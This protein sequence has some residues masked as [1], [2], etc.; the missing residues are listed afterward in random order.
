MPLYSRSA[1]FACLAVIL[2]AFSAGVAAAQAP[3]PTMRAPDGAPA[4][5]KD[6]KIDWKGSWD[7]TLAANL[8]PGKN[9]QKTVEADESLRQGAGVIVRLREIAVL[10]AMVE[11]FPAPTPKRQQ[12]YATIAKA[13]A[14]LGDRARAVGWLKRQ[15]NDYPDAKAAAAEA[16]AGIL[17]YSCPFDSAPEAA[18]WA[19]Y[20]GGGLEA[21]VKAGAVPGNAPAVIQARERLCVA[22]RQGQRPVLARRYLDSLRAAE[23][24][25]KWWQLAKAQLLLGAGH[26]P[27]A[28]GLM[29][30]AGNA[31]QAGAMREQARAGR[32][33]VDVAPLP[34][35]LEQR[36]ER[37]AGAIRL[38][39]TKA[40]QNAESVQD[41]LTR[42]ADSGAI[43][44]VDEELQASSVV[45]LDR[46][47]QALKGELGPLRQWEQQS[48]KRLADALPASGGEDELAKLVRRYPWA[49]RV[50]EV[51]VERGEQALREG[52]YD[53]AAGAFET[54]AAHAEDPAVLAQ[55]R[56]GLWLALGQG[57]AGREAMEQAMAQ[58]PDATA[59]PRGGEAGT[60]GEAKAFVRKVTS[61]AQEAVAPLPRAP[62]QKLQLPAAMAAQAPASRGRYESWSLGPWAIRRIEW[63]GRQLVLSG[64]RYIA[65]YDGSTMALRWHHAAPG[66][67]EAPEETPGES[68]VARI[69]G[70]WRPAALASPYSSSSAGG[71]VVYALF[72][73]GEGGSDLSAFEAASGR[74][75]W[76]TQGR[77]E[78]E[79]MRILSEPTAG[80]D[81]VYVLAMEQ[82]LRGTCS[83]YL[84]CLAADDAK[85]VWK[86]R[87][88]TMGYQDPRMEMAR[89][90]S[91]LAIHQGSL[92]VSTN[93]GILAKCQAR[94]GSLEW[95]RTYYAANP[96]EGAAAR[97]RREGSV[98][99]VIGS[100]VYFAP[101]D[102][103]GVMALDRQTGQLDWESPLVPSDQVLGLAG[104]VMVVRDAEELAALDTATGEELWSIP[105]ESSASAPAVIAGQNILIT[106]GDKLRRISAQTGEVV[107]ETAP[108]KAIGTEQV[109]LPGGV[110]VEISEEVR[111]GVM[112]GESGP[113]AGPLAPP[114]A[115]RW[116]LTCRDPL[117][118]VP[119]SAQP[120]GDLIGVV[121]WEM[122]LRE[123]PDSV[124]FHGRLIV[125]ATGPELLAVDKETGA[126]RWRRTLPFAV[127]LVSGDDRVIVAGRTSPESPAM[128]LAP[129][130]GAV[131][132]HRW[133]GQEPRFTG[134]DRLRWLSVT[135]EPG[136]PPVLRLYWSGALFGREGRR[137]A[138]VIKRQLRG[139]IAVVAMDLREDQNHG[140]R[141]EHHEIRA[142]GKLR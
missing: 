129:E 80:A 50:Q 82:D 133:F 8:D 58:V 94:D 4:A 19:Q 127:D 59:M 6:V 72:G 108:A 67:G 123:P 95:L 130:T 110:L 117:L 101:R 39:G 76:T 109:L 61:G 138:E 102:Y 137:P 99:L 136:A 15:V 21:L 43:Q 13:Y 140:R 103:S 98:P 44:A 28:A 65:C 30:Q 119:P 60:A 79:A 12:A 70:V 5:W 91:G 32:A 86:R 25:N 66:A 42:C 134:A 111:P 132:W 14:G 37:L 118:V 27:Q 68:A 141:D 97:A 1:G 51:L 114:F 124:G 3:L 26:V 53:W 126:V 77:T 57:T 88:G 41:V 35:G 17:E 22:W 38:T 33:D 56:L 135:G 93:M 81:V 113:P 83:V 121:A 90:A 24:G 125:F 74:E 49:Q 45:L 131:L 34:A 92:Y 9:W 105:A 142:V 96:G 73:R 63:Q 75:I 112:A 104:R 78:W 47:L 62:T 48:A 128:G 71:R 85:I 84:L 11:H 40:V 89:Y 120:A 122:P 20:A 46:S 29:Q 64:P 23:S 69:R 106:A 10:E 36:L 52:R 31:Q 87:L 7:E 107:E 100:R 139:H 55:A 116:G 18:A 54:A 16:M 2:V 115:K